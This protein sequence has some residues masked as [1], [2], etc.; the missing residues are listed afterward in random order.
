MRRVAGTRIYMAPEMLRQAHSY[1]T[2]ADMWSM[3]ILLYI[4]LTGCVPFG[5]RDPEKLNKLIM[6]GKIDQLPLRVI[7][8]SSL[9]K[10]LLHEMLIM[11][12]NHRISAHD[13][14]KHP[15]IT[16][17]TYPCNIFFPLKQYKTRL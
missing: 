7:N 11:D 8:P 13:A 14:L 9:A 1:N 2:K 12:P 15:F 6:E 5:E 17:K 3:G 4:M 10:S 16:Q